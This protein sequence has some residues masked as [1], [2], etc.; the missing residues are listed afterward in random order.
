LRRVATPHS[1]RPIAPRRKV[2]RGRRRIREE[3]AMFR[4]IAF[5]LVLM[6]LPACGSKKVV[7]RLDPTTAIDLSGRWNDE[8]S[9]QVSDQFV[10][11]ILQARWLERH[12][13]EHAGEEPIVIVGLVRNK[14][15][16][17]IATETFTKDIE[18]AFINSGIVR[19]VAS[20][21]ERVEVRDEREDQQDFS[22]PETVKK[23]GREHGADYMLMGTINSIEDQEKGE[24]VVFYQVDLEL[25]DIETNEKVWLD[26]KEIKKYIGRSQYKG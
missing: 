21:E 14:S 20:S 3:V 16:E 8:D 22:S 18:R 23:F 13:R 10:D 12:D 17:H 19:V 5:A 11:E 15:T 6:L 26:Q 2:P 9:R 25:T 7:T 1:L 4:P 24:K